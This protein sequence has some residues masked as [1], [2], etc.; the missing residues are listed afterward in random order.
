MYSTVQSESVFF[1]A[2]LISGVALSFLYDILRISRRIVAVNDA[3]INA[4]DILF[5]AAC[6]V[7]FFYVAYLK[8]GGE[9]RLSGFLG[10]FLG[11]ILYAILV[12]NG[13]L[14]LGETVL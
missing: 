10:G 9:V 11:I 6:A 1:L 3:I 5:F 8:N 13:F 12:R 4:Q 2:S 14:N 7:M